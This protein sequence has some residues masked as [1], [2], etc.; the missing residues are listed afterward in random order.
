MQIRGETWGIL[1]RDFVRNPRAFIVQSLLAVLV[2]AAILYF[3]AVL[4]HAAIVAAL[5]SSAFVVFAIPK[6]RIAEA[7][8]LI[9]GHVVGVAV[10]AFCHFV[11]VNGLLSG[12]AAELEFV[13]WVVGGV[14][15]G[16]AVFGMTITNTEH[17]P[18]GGTALGITVH[19][20]SYQTVIFILACVICLAVFR[21]LMGRRLVN[22]Y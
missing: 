3:V 4:T 21:R 6:S 22:L 9:G 15:I 19:G 14:A 7:R 20:W 18:A 12:A 10:G 17:P 1:D 13:T 16:L 2:G 11:C 8:R 5:G